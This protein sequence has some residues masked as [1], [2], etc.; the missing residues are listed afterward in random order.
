[1]LKKKIL[2]PENLTNLSNFQ[3][4]KFTH[5]NGHRL[6]YS[7][8]VCFYIFFFSMDL[9]YDLRKKKKTKLADVNELVYSLT[10]EFDCYTHRLIGAH[11]TYH[12]SINQIPIHT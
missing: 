11:D 3:M 2:H 1:M 4:E 6:I 10:Y 7:N 12:G 5:K 8:S 9:I